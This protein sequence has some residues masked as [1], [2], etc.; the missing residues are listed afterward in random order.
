MIC[1][2]CGNEIQK[3][4]K[5]C[6][7]CGNAVAQ[8][9]KCVKCG[10]ILAPEQKFCPQCGT[11]TDDQVSNDN[12]KAKAKFKSNDN[13]KAKFKSNAV[14]KALKK[15]P[16]N[17]LSDQEVEDI[18]NIIE[19]HALGAG[20]SGVATGWI[21]VAGAAVASV[22]RTA[23]IW[24]MYVRICRRLDINLSKKKLKFLG[25]VV[26]SD[27]AYSVG[28]VLAATAVSLVP[29]IGSV[30]S[31]LLNA[32]I[33]YSMVGV[34]GVMFVR[35]ISSLRDTGTDMANM[36]DEELKER[37]KVIMSKQD[38]KG[39]MKEAQNEYAKARKEGKI[40]GKET[41]DLEEE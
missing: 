10:A 35:L 29:G 16:K 2:T 40:S 8:E 37:M 39:M 31:A 38:V 17:V 33:S 21:P 7:N 34:A 12:A 26:V 24:S 36:T 28:A 19:M 3:G 4:A 27:L 5:F 1:S 6:P 23:F 15:I 9:K 30:T 32:S 13:A 25:S 41:V 22:G 20:A 18:N 11:K 14:T